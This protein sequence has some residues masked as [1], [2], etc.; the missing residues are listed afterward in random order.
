MHLA[1]WAWLCRYNRSWQLVSE[2]DLIGF[3]SRATDTAA[4]WKEDLAAVSGFLWTSTYYCQFSKKKLIEYWVSC[5]G[6]CT[7]QSVV[8]WAL[9]SLVVWACRD[10]DGQCVRCWHLD[11]IPMSSLHMTK[12][13]SCSINAYPQSLQSGKGWILIFSGSQDDVKAVRSKHF[14]I[15]S[16]NIVPI[17]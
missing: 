9:N 5:I 10:W 4:K 14:I 1:I 13:H 6:C 11:V 12:S 3:R 8:F 17:S 7:P 2:K 16:W 15:T